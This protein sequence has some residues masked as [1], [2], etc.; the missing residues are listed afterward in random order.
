MNEKETNKPKESP[1]VKVLLWSIIVGTIS[2]FLGIIFLFFL[3]MIVTEVFF[4]IGACGFLMAILMDTLRP[5]LKKLV[6][7]YHAL[8]SDL[9]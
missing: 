9:E 6:D 1:Y 5:I 7:F 3:P 4:I 2:V 8:T